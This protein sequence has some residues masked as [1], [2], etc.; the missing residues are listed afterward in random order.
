MNRIFLIVGIAFVFGACENSEE[1]FNDLNGSPEV[2][3]VVDEQADTFLSDS[4]KTSGEF[5][6]FPFDFTLEVNDVNGNIEGVGIETV[7]GSPYLLVQFDSIL[8]DL[9]VVNIDTEANSITMTGFFFEEGIHELKFIAVDEFAESDTATLSLNAF[10]NL[11]PVVVHSLEDNQLSSD[12][13]T[14]NLSES[15]DRDSE[16]GGDILTYHYLIDGNST[17]STDSNITWTFPGEGVYSASVFV[18]DNNFEVSETV[19]FNIEI[20]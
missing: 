18:T 19:S 15:F 9:E 5:G 20:N 3:I 16:Y 17:T 13:K 14:I 8:I 4:V 10:N 1:F 6:Q 7:Q 12:L 2:M 11:R